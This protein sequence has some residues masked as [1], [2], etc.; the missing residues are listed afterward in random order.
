MTPITTTTQ[1]EAVPVG[2]VVR[3]AAGTIAAR[4]D[5][6][7][8]VVFGDNRPFPWIALD[9]PATVL[10]PLPAATVKPGREELARTIDPRPWSER[11]HPFRDFAEARTT[12]ELVERDRESVRRIADDVLAI[13]PGKTEAQVRAEALRDAKARI[14]LDFTFS[15]HEV[16]A[17]LDAL[18]DEEAG[19]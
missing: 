4:F 10:W 12:A 18:A 5:Q 19:K 14:A 7:R 11:H 8:G 3:S 13:L 17:W 9:L 15:G 2:H 1:L 6:D 16:A